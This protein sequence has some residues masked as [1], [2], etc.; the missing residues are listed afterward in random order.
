MAFITSMKIGRRLGVGFALVLLLMCAVGCIS[1]VQ[2]SRI[3]DGT[4]AISEDWLPS[5]EALSEIRRRADDVRR[6]S[7]RELLP[8]DE[9]GMSELR[10]RR[11]EGVTGLA[12]ALK[13]YEKYLSS[14]DERRL[15]EAIRSSWARYLET[16]DRIEAL[17]GST[18]V[19]LSNARQLAAGEGV[20]RFAAMLSFIDADTKLNHEGSAREVQ[21][22]S[23]AFLSAR[24]WTLSLMIAAL[25]AGILTAFFI[26]RSITV[27]LQESVRVAEK[28][29]RGDL[30]ST[31]E[32]KG[33]DEISLLLASLQRMNEGLRETVARVLSGSGSITL[34][35]TEIA[36]GNADL[37]QRTEEQA[38]SLQETAASMEQLAATVQSNADDSAKGNSLAWAACQTAGRGEAIVGRV[39]ATMS[40][41]S[42]SSEKVTQII[43]VIEGIALQTNILAINAAVEAARAGEQGRGFAVV[44]SEVRTLAQRSA[45][46]GKEVKNLINKAVS[47]VR[48]GHALVEDAGH[49]MREILESVQRAADLNE[50][51]SAVS[52]QQHLGI[53]QA[54][55]AISQIDEVTQRN[56]ALVEEVS[57]AAQ[58]MAEQSRSLRDIVS[59]F[60]MPEHDRQPSL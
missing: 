39:V 41:I 47:T 11:A 24:R 1:L 34:S 26:T 54:T 33:T 56:A 9:K 3:Y 45:S 57:A 7:L 46:A 15:L 43:S 59:V 20:S 35:A 28:V 30:T 40:E 42:D 12:A 36:T 48:D 60:K 6:V 21:A 10:A 25:I 44:A 31:V 5:V 52:A 19:N 58:S 27:P 38:A 32:A 51:I 37:S 50:K 4:R 29:A 49:T 23:A 13:E 2:S 16:S 55:V 53:A 14:D 22:A 8:V 18:D 17:M